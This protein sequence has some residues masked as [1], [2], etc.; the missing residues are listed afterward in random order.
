MHPPDA[1]ARAPD[2]H[3]DPEGNVLVDS[4]AMATKPE[5]GTALWS[6]PIGPHDVRN[7][8]AEE[9]RVIAVEVKS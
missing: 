4:R 9:L 7:V 8:A 2:H 1:L 3:H 5:V 6:A